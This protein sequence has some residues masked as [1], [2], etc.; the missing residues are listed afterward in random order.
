M[1]KS[2]KD[3]GAWKK[4]GKKKKK[5]SSFIYFEGLIMVLIQ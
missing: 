5:D 4:K 2:P 3:M 1:S